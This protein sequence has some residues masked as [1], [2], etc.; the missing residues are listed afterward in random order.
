[1][2]RVAPFSPNDLLEIDVQP[3]QRGENYRVSLYEMGKA[4]SASG[5]AFTA[6]DAE[7]GRI[8]ICG[9][10]SEWHKE[11]ASLW[12]VFADAKGGNMQLITRRVRSFINQLPHRRVDAMIHSDFGAAARWAKIIGLSHEA[13]LAEAM[14]DGGNAMIFR[15]NA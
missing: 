3:A 15:R 11:H 6:R 10:A 5:M 7:T 13:T 1:M 9:G 12:A 8:L 2:I 14:P 4:Q